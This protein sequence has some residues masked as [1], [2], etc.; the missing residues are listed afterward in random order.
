MNFLTTMDMSPIGAR[1]SDR[2][3]KN[4]MNKRREAIELAAKLLRLTAADAEKYCFDI[5]ELN[6]WYFSVPVKGGDSLVVGDDMTVLYAN[7][8][9]GYPQH[10][11]E[12]KKGTRTPIE[13][14]E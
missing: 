8:S 3:R 2:E 5:P 12:Y 4:R 7:S 13:M 9:V 6:A 10:V 14:F 1:C 11:E